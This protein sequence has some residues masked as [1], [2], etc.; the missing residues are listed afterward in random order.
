MA[1]RSYCDISK[2]PK[3]IRRMC[4]LQDCTQPQWV[5]LINSQKKTVLFFDTQH[6]ISVSHQNI[7]YYFSVLCIVLH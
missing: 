5:D 7:K 6:Y 3:P 2:K 1:H 4:N